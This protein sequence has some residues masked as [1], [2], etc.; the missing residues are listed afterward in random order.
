[1]GEPV[2]SKDHG[3]RFVNRSYV[4]CQRVSFPVENVIGS[5]IDLSI[6]VREEPSK[7]RRQSFR[8]DFVRRE[9]FL[10]KDGDMKQ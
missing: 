6:V 1:V 9:Y 8:I 5:S 7:S 10:I 2:I 3:T 4:K